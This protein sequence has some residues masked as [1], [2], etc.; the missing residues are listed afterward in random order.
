M[1]NEEAEH[2]HAG[3]QMNDDTSQPP[4]VIYVDVDDTLIRTIG[5]KRIP[6]SEAVEHVR[7]LFSQGA[8]LFCWSSGGGEYALL[9]AKELGIEGC[10][11]AFLPKPQVL[12]DDQAIADWRRLVSVH[13]L[14]CSTESVESYRLAILSGRKTVS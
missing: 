2:R 12:L 8:Q 7:L 5:L 10:F 14:Q 4:L 6:I 9:A 1:Q 13:P 3:V 11:K